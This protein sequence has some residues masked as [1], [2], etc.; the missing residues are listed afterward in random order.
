MVI[1]MRFS[2]GS[3]KVLGKGLLCSERMVSVPLQHF[4]DTTAS[5]TKSLK[6][7]GYSKHKWSSGWYRKTNCQPSKLSLKV[8]NCEKDNM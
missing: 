1:L 6:Q 8:G 3:Y 4:T 2:D 5:L 7:S